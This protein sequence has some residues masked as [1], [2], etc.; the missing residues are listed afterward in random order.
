MSRILGACQCEA[1][2]QAFRDYLK[3]KNTLKTG[4]HFNMHLL[5]EAF[6]LFHDNYDRLGGFDGDKHRLYLT[7]VIGYI[8]RYVPACL[9]RAY[10]Q[11]LYAI[12]DGG[13]KLERHLQFLC[14]GDEAVYFFPLDYNPRYRLGYTCSALS[15]LGYLHRTPRDE[16]LVDC[17][18]QL[19]L[20]KNSKL[21]KLIQP[22]PTNACCVIF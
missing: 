2:L 14:N 20:S 17:H 5:L 7:K 9:A 19:M 15:L 22:T 18:S 12:T 21:A 4:K 3:P 13:E 8:Q 10:C 6:Q 11:R 1:A 16:D